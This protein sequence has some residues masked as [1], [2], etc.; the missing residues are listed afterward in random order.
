M[1]DGGKLTIETQNVFLD[2]DYADT[3]LEVKQGDY[4]MVSVADTGT[5][6]SR[7][8]AERAF[9]PFFTT[10][11][12]GIGTG[13]GLSMIYGFVKQSHGHVSIYSEPG[14]GTIVKMYLP[15]ARAEAASDVSPAAVASVPRGNERIL[16]VED[17]ALVRRHAVAVL[18]GLG[19][20]VTACEDG[21]SAL[22]S[23]AAEGPFDLLLV[24]VVLGGGMN[25]RQVAEA[26]AARN[27]ALKILF[28]SGYTE[29]AIAHHGR[30]DSGVQLLGKPFRRAEIAA[31]VRKVL[32]A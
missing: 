25:G 31:K 28:M 19:Y 24:D 8:T 13:L 3:R 18:I 4:V 32:D 11:P 14:Q 12:A 15:R 26:I 22:R 20:R 5:G 6:M 23:F 2:A 27:P 29:N 30:L 10:K 7:Q 1:P 21:P 9:E 17:D 16:L